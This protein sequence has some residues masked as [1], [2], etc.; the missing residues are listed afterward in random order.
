MSSF[1]DYMSNMIKNDACVSAWDFRQGRLLKKYRGRLENFKREPEELGY[2]WIVDMLS[3]PTSREHVEEYLY[4]QLKDTARIMAQLD[5]FHEN[6]YHWVVKQNALL[7][8]AK[9]LLEA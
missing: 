6:H 1:D 3:R 8:F 2:S 5:R 4:E 7:D 9:E